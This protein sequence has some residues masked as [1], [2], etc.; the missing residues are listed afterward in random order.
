VVPGG[1]LGVSRA[2]VHGDRAGIVSEVATI[3]RAE[4]KDIELPVSISPQ[5]CTAAACNTENTSNSDTP[6]RIISRAV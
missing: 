4:I 2:A 1:Q 3:G 6:G 5:A